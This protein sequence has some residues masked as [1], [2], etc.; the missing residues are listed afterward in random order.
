MEIDPIISYNFTGAEPSLFIM[1]TF[2]R[3]DSQ[4]HVDKAL[5]LLH[6]FRHAFS[7]VFIVAI[8]IAFV[9]CASSGRRITTG[10]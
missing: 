8:G 10:S 2:E 5:N 1:V 9:G 3:G 4:R 7:V 6:Y